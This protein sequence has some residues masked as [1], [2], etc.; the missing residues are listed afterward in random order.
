[1]IWLLLLI[2]HSHAFCVT[3]YGTPRHLGNARRFSRNVIASECLNKVLFG[4]E[5]LRYWIKLLLHKGYSLTFQTHR[6]G[7]LSCSW[8]TKN[9]SF[10]SVTLHPPAQ[11]HP[12]YFSYCPAPRPSP[13]NVIFFFQ[14]ESVSKRLFHIIKT[15]F[16]LRRHPRSFCLMSY[17]RD[18][19]RICHRR[20][21]SPNFAWRTWCYRLY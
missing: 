9:Y 5:N 6:C 17:H 8:P 2:R 13:V 16:A 10:L 21:F 14:L 15:S 7:L 4:G 19:H 20:R 12:T 18:S 11:V 3:I 1:M